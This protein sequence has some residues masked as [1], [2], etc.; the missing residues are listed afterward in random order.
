MR[1]G[2]HGEAIALDG[3]PQVVPIPA[4]DPPEPV[5]QPYGRAPRPRLPGNATRRT[6]PE[7]AMPQ[8][9]VVSGMDEELR[10]TG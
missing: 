8:A 10:Q 5:E 3:E 6:F 9:A 4:F 1:L 2:H 7:I